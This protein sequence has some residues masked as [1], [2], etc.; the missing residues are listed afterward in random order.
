MNR[1]TRRNHSRSCWCCR[2]RLRVRCWVEGSQ[3]LRWEL[4][5]GRL[6]SIV[7]LSRSFNKCRVIC[8]SRA[9]LIGLLRAGGCF[10]SSRTI[11]SKSYVYSFDGETR[12]SIV[13]Y[14]AFSLTFG[15]L[16][17]TL[18]ESLVCYARCCG[19]V[20]SVTTLGAIFAKVHAFRLDRHWPNL[21]LMELPTHYS[22][23]ARHSYLHQAVANC[24]TSPSS[25]TELS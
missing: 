25:S 6:K 4:A 2:R 10:T 8:W 13:G 14:Y 19:V 17:P 21:H 9:E 15:T 20:R 24:V 22:L 5:L 12:C 18:K 3:F 16:R 11:K 1:A 23:F 7:K